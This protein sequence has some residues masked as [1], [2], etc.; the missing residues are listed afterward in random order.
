V[1]NASTGTA[2]RAPPPAYHGDWTRDSP[3]LGRPAADR[4]PHRRTPADGGSVGLQPSARLGPGVAG[5]A[6]RLCARWR[7]HRAIPASRVS[8]SLAL[9]HA[10]P[11]PVR[12]LRPRA[13][14]ASWVLPTPGAR[15]HH[16]GP[17]PARFSCNQGGP[18]LETEPRRDTPTMTRSPLSSARTGARSR[19]PTRHDDRRVHYPA[20]RDVRLPFDRP[21]TTDPAYPPQRG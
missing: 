16:R 2:S 6:C 18:G 10:T 13:A 11:P 15:E 19:L 4:D 12:Q 17:G 21:D 7:R 20:P 5:P 1:L 8:W 9:T 14:A 3:A